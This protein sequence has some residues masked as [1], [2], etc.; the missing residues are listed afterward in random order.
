MLGMDNNLV[1]IIG[2]VASLAA[3]II[4]LVTITRFQ[5]KSLKTEL[6]K[7][8]NARFDKV[9]AE[10]KTVDTRFEA[11]KTEMDARF[12]KVD[13]EF[14]NVYARFDKVDERFKQVDARFDKVDARFGTE[15]KK[16]DDRFDRI[17]SRIAVLDGRVYDLALTVGGLRND[18]QEIRKENQAEARRG[19]LLTSAATA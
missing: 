3:I 13:A 15:S 5:T 19:G 17:E 7:T 4:A 16:G 9:D 8:M 18:V 6:E 1:T 11:L 14:Q 2:L 10:F 12:D